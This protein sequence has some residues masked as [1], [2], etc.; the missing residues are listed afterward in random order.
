MENTSFT[1][2]RF[3]RSKYENDLIM[4]YI[5]KHK[6]TKLAIID[7]EKN[8]AVV[9]YNKT[10]MCASSVYL[11][12]IY[13]D[14]E[15]D[16]ETTPIKTPI[17][18]DLT[19]KALDLLFGV[20][21]GFELNFTM[22][23]AFQILK[24]FDCLNLAPTVTSAFEE[25]VYECLAPDNYMGCYDIYSAGTGLV[26]LTE[27]IMTLDFAHVFLQSEEN[28]SKSAIDWVIKSKWNNN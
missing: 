12:T 3:V 18:L 15:S 23:E 9:K 21:D 19:L 16:A 2:A 28:R 5:I 7:S 27:F 14:L 17:S 4:S 26:L 11:R 20:D 1:L 24:L 8:E 22:C 10:L 6:D 25:C 13:D